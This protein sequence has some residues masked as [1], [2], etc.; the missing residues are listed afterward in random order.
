MTS[1]ATAETALV[2]LDASAALFDWT[3]EHLRLVLPIHERDDPIGRADRHLHA[4]LAILIGIA[5]P[6]QQP[7]RDIYA[8]SDAFSIVTTNALPGQYPSPRTQKCF[9]A[10][11]EPVRDE[12]RWDGVVRS[13]HECNAALQTGSPTGAPPLVGIDAAVRRHAR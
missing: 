4:D 9:V 10:E 5:R 2:I 6:T 13:A 1:S 11:L 8:I 12:P 3:R 7:T